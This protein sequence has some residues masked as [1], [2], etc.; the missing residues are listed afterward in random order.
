MLKTF[1]KTIS[2]TIDDIIGIIP[3]G[4]CTT[5]IKLLEDCKSSMEHQRRLNPPMQEIVKKEI[6]K[7]LDTGVIYLIAN[8]NWVSLLQYIK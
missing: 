2:W 7:W 3:S 5:K 1:I 8:G 6:I 4:I